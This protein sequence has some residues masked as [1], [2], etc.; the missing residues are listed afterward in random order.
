MKNFTGGQNQALD[1]PFIGENLLK[2]I[3]NENSDWIIPILGGNGG[4]SRN[5]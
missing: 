3:R 2:V 1:D 5:D 4:S